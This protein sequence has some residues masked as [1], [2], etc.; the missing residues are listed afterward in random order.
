MK[1]PK[2]RACLGH[3]ATAVQ[4]QKKERPARAEKCEP[5]RFQNRDF[6]LPTTPP[7][8]FHSTQQQTITQASPTFTTIHPHYLPNNRKNVYY[9]GR[10]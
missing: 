6:L 4:P 2:C 9:S 10:L 8:A 5:P 1:W 3:R 7:R